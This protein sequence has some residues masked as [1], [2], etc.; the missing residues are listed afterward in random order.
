MP[1]REQSPSR[2]LLQMQKLDRQQWDSA[3][4]WTQWL[5]M[6]RAPVFPMTIMAGLSAVLMA[7]KDGFFYPD[8]AFILLLGLTLAHAANNLLND[9]VD[10]E[11]GID[12][13]N[14]FRNRYGV[15]VLEQGFVSRKAFVMVL[16]LHA[17]MAMACAVYLYSQTGQ[18]VLYLI[19]AGAFFAIFYTWPLKHWALGELSVLLVWGPLM[20][21]GGYLVMTGTVTSRIILLAIVYGIGPVLVIMGK[22]LDKYEDDRARQVR[23]LPVVVGKVP[24]RRL[25]VLFILVQWWL[26]G[27]LVTAFPPGWLPVCL[28]SLPALI[29]ALRCFLR[30][31]PSARPDGFPENVWPLW[32]SA[33]AFR[34]SQHF[35]LS[36]LLALGLDVLWQ[37]GSAEIP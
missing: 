27:Y 10:H 15:Q 25:S 5:V 7:W 16:G 29:M 26:L 31:A 36:F 13:E 19:L 8:R 2:F 11:R 32:Y 33:M 30:D 4:R 34:Y 12:R 18:P 35:G 1:G 17:L 23:S 22:H 14:Y 3:G 9:L 20:V 6:V 21:A 24:A 28:L 37:V